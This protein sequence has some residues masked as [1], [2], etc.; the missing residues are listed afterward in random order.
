MRSSVGGRLACFHVSAIGNNAVMN[1]SA[2]LSLRPWLRFLQIRAQSGAAGLGGSIT[3][4]AV[5]NTS[6]MSYNYNFVAVSTFKN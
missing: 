2:A 4:I 5:A 6:M 3:A 1:E